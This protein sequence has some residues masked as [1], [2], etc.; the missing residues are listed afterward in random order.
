MSV[1][2]GDA[3]APGA[4][5]V[6]LAGA[7]AALG[8]VLPIL[9]HMIGMGRTFLPMHLPVLVAGLLLGPRIAWTVGLVVPWLSSLLT[10][11]PPMPMPVLMSLELVVLAELASLL[12]AGRVPVWAAA[13]AAI[14]GRCAVTWIFTTLLASY[15]GLPPRSVG[16]A[17]IASGAPGI[18]LQVVLAPAMAFGFVRRRPASG[19]HPGQA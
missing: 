14:C 17:S 2:E 18:V 12:V 6:A 10:G 7:F 19:S 4:R 1:S 8:V 11:M 3:H 16:W 13:I 5:E 9:F 15:L